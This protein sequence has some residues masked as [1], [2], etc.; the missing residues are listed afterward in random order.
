MQ[1]SATVSGYVSDA[2]DGFKIKGAWAVLDGT[3][4]SDYTDCWGYFRI[5]GIPV[6]PIRVNFTADDTIGYTPF[7][8]KFTCESQGGMPLLKII[9][10]DYHEWQ[11]KI[12]IEEG[13]VTHLHPWLKPLGEMRI[14]CEWNYYQYMN[15]V[16]AILKTPYIEEQGYE[17]NSINP[18]GS[19]TEPPFALFKEEEDN[20][21][22]LIYLTFRELFPGTYRYYLNVDKFGVGWGFDI[23]VVRIFDEDSLVN[24]ITTN[25]VGEGNFW[26][27]C[28][29]NGCCGGVTIINEWWEDPPPA[30]KNSMN[31]KE[32]NGTH[33]P[34]LSH[35]G[36][37]TYHWDFGDGSNSEEQNPSHTYVNPGVY[38]VS[39]TV[40]DG[41][42]EA[43]ETKTSFIHTGGAGIE[44]FTNQTISAFPNPARTVVSLQLSEAKSAPGG[45]PVFSIGELDIAL[46]NANGALVNE[47]KVLTHDQ[48]VTFNVHYLPAGIY[49]IKVVKEGD[50]NL[51]AKLVK[52]E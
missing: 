29:I 49:F 24:I 44:D 16:V 47:F 37:R 10:D 7:T 4:Y 39:L 18:K 20:D 13:E 41:F 1:D 2:F 23:P 46:F 26:Y 50:I 28:D 40:S 19:L 21:N 15:D 42:S 27:V 32:N 48:I 43:T 36:F 9:H 12:L 52:I 30:A 33:S 51:I 31:I 45:S 14:S 22:K 8:V 3:S 38:D 25:I 17:I 6:D 34:K 5:E 11:D 35:G